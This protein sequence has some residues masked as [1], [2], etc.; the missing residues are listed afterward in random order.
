MQLHALIIFI[1]CL[2]R[3]DKESPA[4]KMPERPKRKFSLWNLQ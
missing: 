3:K 1:L 4:K 2:L